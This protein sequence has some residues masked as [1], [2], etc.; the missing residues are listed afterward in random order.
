[1]KVRNI[2]NQDLKISL[3]VN[4]EI[5]SVTVKPNQVMYCEDKS[6]INKQLLIYEKKKLVNI[7]K[8][9]EKPDYVEHYKSF[10]ESGTYSTAKP[11]EPIDLDDDIEMTEMQEAD[12]EPERFEEIDIDEIDDQAEEPVKKGR[13]RPKKP[14]DESA[15]TLEKKGRGRPKGSTKSKEA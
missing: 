4:N 12:L 3:R 2:S 9:A 10:F 14:V 7:E 11:V 6:Q 13:G 1:M 15:T 5:R 8:Q